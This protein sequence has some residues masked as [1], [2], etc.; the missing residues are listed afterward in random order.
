MLDVYESVFGSVDAFVYRCKNDKDYTMDFM[1]GAVEKIIGYRPEQV[2]GNRN[3]SY[4]GLTSQEDVDRVFADVD[5]AIEQKRPW[6][7]FYR[8]KHNSGRLV[9]VRE[10]GS[11]VYEDGQLAYLQ[12]L[13]I[14]AD[15]EKALTDDIE[16]MLTASTKTNADIVEI[17]TEITQSLKML[18]ILSI[19]AKVEAARIGEQGSGF[20]IVA[21][22]IKKLAD[23]NTKWT[24]LIQ[25]RL[26][27]T[28][29]QSVSS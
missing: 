1:E 28:E 15:A 11:A 17:T 20:A 10:L 4:V 6:N 2:L 25:K 21:D 16:E 19:N 7:V 14:S 23:Q 29:P 9:P 22:E 26:N 24:G 18:N 12:G 8:L 13:V 27:D 3:V 5:D